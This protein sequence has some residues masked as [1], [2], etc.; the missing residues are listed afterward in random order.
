MGINTSVI[1]ND[2]TG[3]GDLVK[4]EID[5]VDQYTNG[6]VNVEID[7]TNRTLSRHPTGVKIFYDD[8]KDEL[9]ITTE[10][11]EGS[12]QG[13]YQNISNYQEQTDAPVSSSVVSAIELLYEESEDLNQSMLE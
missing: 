5:A 13:T 10:S 4:Y 12:L 11:G 9:F 2:Y 8:T 6:S 3:A 1:D 7:I